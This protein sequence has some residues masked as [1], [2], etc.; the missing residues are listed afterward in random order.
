MSVKIAAQLRVANSSVFRSPT[1]CPSTLRLTHHFTCSSVGRLPKYQKSLTRA[2]EGSSSRTSP[3]PK[4]AASNKRTRDADEASSTR[5]GSG[6]AATSKLGQISFELT[7]PFPEQDLSSTRPAKLEAPEAPSPAQFGGVVPVSERAKYLYRTG[8]SYLSFYKTGLKNI[9]SNYKEYQ[10]IKQR[11]GGRSI[12]DA[13]KYGYSDGQPISRRDYQ[14]YLR[15]KHDI[16]KLIPFGLIFLIC[17]EFTPLVVFA[18]GS[19]VVPATCRIPKQVTHDRV[20]T[21]RRWLEPR[22]ITSDGKADIAEREAEKAS[23]TAKPGDH[24]YGR[25]QDFN[26]PTCKVLVAQ[27]ALSTVNECASNTAAGGLPKGNNAPLSP[28]L[29]RN[30]ERLE[31]CMAYLWGLSPTPVPSPSAP[32]RFLNKITSFRRLKRH[33]EEVLCDAILIIREGGIARLDGDE[34]VIWCFSYN[35]AVIAQLEINNS[36][37]LYKAL[38][39]PVA[40]AYIEREFNQD[41][42]AMLLALRAVEYEPQMHYLAGL[43]RSVSYLSIREYSDHAGKGKP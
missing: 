42:A 21:A 17:G 2:R 4:T 15:T 9:W 20:G 30:L 14:M 33:A 24:A 38:P 36:E 5:G 32:V 29:A 34:A 7:Q 37:D 39:L 28:E 23:N 43:V 41:V 40:S 22:I 19:R 8:R 35:S 1:V 18:L 25:I 10:V 3:V 13:A 12:T 26:I 6:V 16:W 11:L 31:M 27:D